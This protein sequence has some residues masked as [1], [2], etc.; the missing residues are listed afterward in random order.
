MSDFLQKNSTLTTIFVGTVMVVVG[1]ALVR[2]HILV[3]VSDI[4][5][6]FSYLFAVLS[7][8]YGAIY[9][10]AN[11][12]WNRRQLGATVSFEV[13]TKTIDPAVIILNKAFNF[14]VREVKESISVDEIH[15]K[16]CQKD[17]AGK[18]KKGKKTDFCL[19]VDGEGHSIYMAIGSLLNAFEYIAMG[20]HQK[21]FD[22]EIIRSVYEGMVVKTY[23]NFKAYIDHINNE[24]VPDRKGKIWINFCDLAEGYCN[25]PKASKRKGTG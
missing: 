23:H 15:D 1:I 24:M 22:E 25:K 19:I 4:V 12:D 11:H 5:R 16:I 17:E 9:F 6:Y 3:D 14:S 21:V 7:L 8:F 2:W 10:K 13:K 18:L 20:V